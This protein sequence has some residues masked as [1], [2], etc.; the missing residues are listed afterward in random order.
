MD[1][2]LARAENAIRDYLETG[3]ALRTLVAKKDIPV[4][5]AMA[6][7]IVQCLSNG[8]RLLLCGNGGSAA[9]AQHIAAEF[10]NKFYR[11]G[12]ALSAM[13]LTTDTS[14]LTAIAND[15]SYD[16]V[17]ARQVE[18]HGRRG[19]CL[20]AISTSGNSRNVIKAVETARVRGLSIIGLTGRTGEG[21]A[22]KCDIALRVPSVD[23]PQIQEVHIAVGHILSKLAEDVLRG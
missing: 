7:L 22:S 14:V 10:V 3:A 23:T 18:A 16:E 12:R 6:E 4:I 19:D 5:R 21:L 2:E 1:R 17:F 11:T 9:D 13:A 8:G 20:V 15:S